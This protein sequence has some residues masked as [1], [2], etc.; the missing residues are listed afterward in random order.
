MFM[1]TPPDAF[2]VLGGFF[3]DFPDLQRKT[4]N[5]A[6]TGKAKVDLR[7]N[8]ADRFEIGF[9]IDLSLHKF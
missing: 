9:N 5:T 6:I 1:D 2:S 7:R 8:S 4:S 3:P